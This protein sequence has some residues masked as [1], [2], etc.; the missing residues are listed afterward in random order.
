MPAP[1]GTDTIDHWTQQRAQNPPPSF[2]PYEAAAQ[3]VMPAAAAAP[4]T[5]PRAAGLTPFRFGCRLARGDRIPSA[6][7]A[8]DAVGTSGTIE[9][10]RLSIPRVSAA[11]ADGDCANE[12][13]GAAR[14][15]PAVT[16][17]TSIGDMMLSNLTPEGDKRV[18]LSSKAVGW[19]RQVTD[20]GAAAGV[21]SRPCLCE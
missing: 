16:A 7:T 12:P 14:I 3:A 13:A 11:T 10:D 17:M 5:A 19:L 8:A 18:G 6:S 4:M 15:A 9:P 20:P 2:S 21:C 1:T